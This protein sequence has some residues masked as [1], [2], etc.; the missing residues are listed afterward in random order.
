MHNNISYTLKNDL[1][2]GCG[3][4]KGACP[5]NA[6]SIITQNGRFLP[7]VD[8]ALCKN[9]KGCHRCIDTCPGIGIDLTRI[10][11]EQ[12]TSN[13][14]KSDKM[15]GRYLKCFVG[16]S[17]NQEI[18]YHCAS[19]GMTSQFLIYLLNKKY[20]DGAIVTAFDPSNEFLVKTYIATN[21][22][23]VLAAKGSKYSPVSFHNIV[24]EIKKAQGNR[25]V[26]VGLPCHIHGFRKLE[27][28]DRRFK[29]KIIGYFT[30]F[31]SSGRTFNLTDYLFRE[32]KVAKQNL[33]YFS[34]RDEGCLGSMVIQEKNGRKI[35]DKY[36]NYYHPLRSFFIPR[37]CLFC[38]DHYGE[39]ADIC[40]GDIHIEPYI[41]DKIGI[42]SIIVRKQQWL[43]WILEAQKEGYIEIQEI[44]S[45]ILN[46]SQKMS[47]KKKGRNGEFISLNKR[48]GREIPK[49]DVNYLKP[50]SI[51]TIFNYIQNRCQQFIGCHKSL[52]WL[53]APLKKDTS[54]LK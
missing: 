49:Y 36:Q 9:D 48:F 29:E 3:I 4:C 19:G 47:N 2:T 52:W 24:T 32:R 54:N 34:Y 15:I 42:N 33:T 40:F 17:N 53:I 35:V 43:D 18:R 45:T 27:S 51:K 7:K 44:S 14:T 20:I 23:E 26:I 28:I 1:C 50:A 16:H 39:L 13:S 31:C 8:T 5:S 6:I 21:E 38:I 46:S 22:K 41:Q 30:I 12:F 11:Q 25:Y 37:R 10:A